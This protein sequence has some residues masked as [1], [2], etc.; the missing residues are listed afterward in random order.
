MTEMVT[1]WDLVEWQVRIAGGGWTIAGRHR[2]ARPFHRGA[3]LCGKI[4]PPLPADGRARARIARAPGRGVRE[5]IPVCVKGMTVGSD[6]DP[7]LAKSDCLWRRSGGCA[8]NAGPGALRDRCAGCGNECEIPAF[9]ACRRRCSRWSARH[10]FA[11]PPLRRFR[12]R[13]AT[14]EAFAAAAYSWLKRWKSASPDPWDTPSSGWRLG[15]SAPTSVRLRCGERV[16]HVHIT[17]VPANA[18]ARED[19]ATGSLSAA[20]AGDRFG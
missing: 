3:G 6:Y 2:T 1:G 16:D 12:R 13:R 9:P 17:G 15:A 10:R 4:R 20:L 7:M 5:W 18:V 19:G 11:R 8:A 14:D